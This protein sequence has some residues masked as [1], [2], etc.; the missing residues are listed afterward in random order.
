MRNRTQQFKN[1]Q[2]RK[3]TLIELLVVIAII[4]ILAS[5]LLPALN[6]ARAM[7]KRS[8]CSGN[9]K[10]F[11]SALQMYADDNKG[12]GI[13]N[14]ESSGN[15]PNVHDPTLLAGY[16]VPANLIPTA[17]S[18]KRS[19]KVLAC[20]G[21]DP[22]STVYGDNHPPGQVVQNRLYSTYNIFFSTGI[23]TKDSCWFGWYYSSNREEYSLPCP[24]LKYLGK[25]IT[26]PEGNSGPVDNPATAA[27]VGDRA[28]GGAKINNAKQHDG[29]YNN[30]FFDGHVTFTPWQKLN[31]QISGNTDGGM[32]KWNKN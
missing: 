4:A 28:F 6:R 30:A 22:S 17:S 10:Q 8:S 26:S 19:S 13:H 18:Q 27:T 1:C 24:N 31:Y 29:G 23:R 12:Q 20:P 14:K 9:V 15:Y 21:V 32:L 5:M 11:S 2:S 7:A 25:T 16:L 3:F